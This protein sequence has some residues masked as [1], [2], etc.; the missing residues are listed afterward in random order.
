[1]TP[2]E[3]AEELVFQFKIEIH[4]HVPS[5]QSRIFE[6]CVLKSAKQCAL[7]AVD[8][9]IKLYE[10]LKPHRGFKISYWDEVK[11]EIEKL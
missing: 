3:K 6:S 2:K 9:L 7:I 11:Q 1:M 10:I 5:L 8:E 4:N